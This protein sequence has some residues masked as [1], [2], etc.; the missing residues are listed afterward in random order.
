L[1]HGIA[2]EQG[3]AGG[4]NDENFEEKFHGEV[5]TSFALE[6]GQGKS[7]GKFPEFPK[8]IKPLISGESCS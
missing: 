6:I 5:R 3:K 2:D 8:A 4:L 1:R 7:S